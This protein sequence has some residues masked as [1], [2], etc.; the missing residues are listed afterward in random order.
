MTLFGRIETKLS[1]EQVVRSRRALVRECRVPLSDMAELFRVL[2]AR[3]TSAMR[4][5]R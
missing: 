4:N 5:A 1:V 2:A 3:R